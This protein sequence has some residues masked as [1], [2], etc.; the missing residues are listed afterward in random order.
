MTTENPVLETQFPERPPIPFL[1]KWRSFGTGLGVEVGSQ[2]LE[3]ILT[4]VRPN[5]IRVIDAFTVLRYR[6]RPAAEWGADVLAFLQKNKITHMSAAVVLPTQDCIS[7]SIALTGVP[8]SAVDAAIRYQ[9]DGLHPFTEEEATHSFS[10]LQAPRRSSF[11]LGI[12]R[13]SAIEDYATLFDEAGIDVSSFLTPAAAIY[14][15]LRILQQ[16]PAEQFLAIHEDESGLI[17]YGETNTHPIYCVRFPENSDRAVSSASSQIR[18]PEDAP[19]ARL[20]ALLP[21]AERLEIGS[22]LSYAASLAGA[23]PAQALSMN[24]LPVDRR[25]TSS[26]WRWVPTSVLLILLMA[27]GLAFAFYQDYENRR[28]LTRLDAEIAR[29]QPR[30]DSIKKLDSDIASAEKKAQFLAT[31][32]SYPQQDLDSLRELTRIMPMTSFVSRMGLTRAEL[33]MTGEIDQS[34]E[35]LR[36]LDSSP[37]F[38]D[39]EFTSAPGR[40]LTGKEVFQVRAK[41]ELP[42]A[43]SPNP[44][45]AGPQQVS[46]VGNSTPLPRIAPPPPLP[47]GLRP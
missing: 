43:A 5:G 1:Q 33:T 40:T 46:P 34:M 22:P 21:H 7:R 13:N 10:R 44:Q 24:L 41:R 6:E 15:A 16:A 9:L 19:V 8:N 20:A 35:M 37:L 28:L 45:A 2:N 3:F 27:L 17:L 47:P 31:F 18:L 12:A 11:A 42:S 39:S 26:P 23:L 38:K 30:I 14:S 4:S 29:L 32:S 25:K 36:M